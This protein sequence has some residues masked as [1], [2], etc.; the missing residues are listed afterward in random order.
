MEYTLYIDESG[1]FESLR[2]QWVLAGVLLKGRYNECEKI[3][4]SKLSTLPKELGINS[5][6]D[7]HL[8]EFRR[9]YGHKEA[10]S[11]AQVLFKK[12]ERLTLTPHYLVTINHTKLALSH[13]EKTYRLMLSDLLSLC[14]VSLSDDQSITHLD[15][16]V[17]S[18]TIDGELQ[19]SLSNIN[20][21]VINSLPIALE[22]DLATKGMVNLI[23][24][25]LEVTMDYANRSW[26]LVCADFLANINYHNRKENEKKLL[27]GLSNYNIFE[28][29]G[30]LAMRR[31]AISEREDDF[32]LSLYRW[33]LIL[34]DQKETE[35]AKEAISRLFFKI[36]NRLGT[37]G[38]A[39]S[40]E[41][42]LEKFWRKFNSINLYHKLLQIL[43]LFESEY[44]AYLSNSVSDNH[45]QLIFKLRN[46]MVIVA[47]HCA[48]NNLAN[49][50]ASKQNHT[51][52]QL[53]SNPEYFQYI[54]D[55]KV[56]E[57]EIYVNALDMEKA[58]ELAV[59][60]SKLIGNYKEIWQLLIEENEEEAFSFSSSR[61]YIKSKMALFRCSL[62]VIKNN[63][64]DSFNA[65]YS[66]Y[67]AIKPLVVNSIDLSRLRNYYQMFLL[68]SDQPEKA[69]SIY[70]E[71]YAKDDYKF[72]EFDFL[73]FLKSI[74]D[75]LLAKKQISIDK[76]SDA[77][78]TVALQMDLNVKG[79]PVDLILR[80]MALLEFFKGVTDHPNGA[81]H[82]RP[83]GATL[84]C[85][86]PPQTGCIFSLF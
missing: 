31:A 7:F 69:I 56:I 37:T 46:L 1:D 74:N 52:F 41:A 73:W 83:N 39:T 25:H 50:I 35:C 12:F 21:D 79:H 45:P 66:D 23:G 19:T 15:F 57:I 86:I 72:N 26:G 29:F 75:A 27:K 81:T 78:K 77:V 76:L 28:S 34:H 13:K 20:N 18:R 42:I 68:K 64:H 47:N 71:L 51:I 44:L 16:I 62:L 82:V 63:D 6:K 58:K 40:Y 5:I 14:E 60:Y 3:L 22:V 10:V 43:I 33:I 36:F 70:T 11:K 53:A 4:S 65:L 84:G 67:N 9:K 24:K 59:N 49:K 55:F 17:A 80:E 2:G 32:V 30:G 8:T 48:E 38:A 85:H 61:I 54:L